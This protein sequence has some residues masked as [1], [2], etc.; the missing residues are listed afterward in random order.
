MLLVLLVLLWHRGQVVLLALVLVLVLV[1]VLLWHR[2]QVVVVLLLDRKLCCG[3]RHGVVAAAVCR[4]WA[5]AL[6][7]LQTVQS[8]IA[9]CTERAAVRAVGCCRVAAAADHV[10]CCLQLLRRVVGALRLR[11]CV[12]ASTVPYGQRVQQGAAAR[13]MHW[14]CVGGGSTLVHWC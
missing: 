2:G 7:V 4:C 6:R 9:A 5:T 11:C 8:A 3:A 12:D 10:H 1:L 13:E 14:C